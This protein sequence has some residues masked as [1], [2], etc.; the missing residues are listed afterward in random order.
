MIAP[1]W[2]T[3]QVAIVPMP[4]RDRLEDEMLALREA[5]VDVVASILEAQEAEYLGLS[6]E[7]TAAARAGISFIRFPVPDGGIPADLGA[8]VKFLIELEKQIEDGKRIGIH[9]HGC[10][11]RSPMVA[12]SLL[13]RSGVPS[14]QAWKQVLTARGCPVGTEEQRS[15]VNHHIK[16]ISR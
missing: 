13:I 6:D 14:E 11:G 15:W 5:R 3:H 4:Q 10:V 2:I 7:E 16:A 1:Y 8:F 12:V 9:C